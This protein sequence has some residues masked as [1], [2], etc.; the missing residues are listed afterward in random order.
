M[1]YHADAIG[2]SEDNAQTYPGL[3]S[4]AVPVYHQASRDKKLREALSR[5]GAEWDKGNGAGFNF[6]QTFHRGTLL[7]IAALKVQFNIDP[8]DQL[9]DTSKHL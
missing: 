7:A 9:M 6:K 4:C 2:Q 8:I 5:I 3:W 1:R